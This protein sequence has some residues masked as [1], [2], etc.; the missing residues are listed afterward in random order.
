MLRKLQDPDRQAIDLIL[1]RF[2]TTG[3][4]DAP[5]A[6]AGAPAEP[7]VQSVQK[8]LDL[9]E[10]MP[11]AEPAPDLAARTLQLIDRAPVPASQ[12]PAYLN[13]PHLSA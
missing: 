6:V 2:T 11:A 8:I 7:H 5:I 9:L 1:D 13:P 4:D 10:A 12:P 3:R